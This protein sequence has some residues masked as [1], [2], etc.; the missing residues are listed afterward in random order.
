MN[1]SW[2]IHDFFAGVIRGTTV[3][4]SDN[5]LPSLMACGCSLTAGEIETGPPLWCC[6]PIFSFAFL[7]LFSLVFLQRPVDLTTCP[8]HRSFFFPQLLIS[9]R[10]DRMLRCLL[11]ECVG[12]TM[13]S[14]VTIWR[15]AP[16]EYQRRAASS[17]TSLQAAGGIASKGSRTNT[18]GQLPLPRL[19]QSAVLVLKPKHHR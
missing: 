9:L 13:V 5:L 3:D 14:K 8:N 19:I 15:C 11:Q 2:I 6:L 12:F 10:N 17:P 16:E 4:I 1:I 18:P 7:F